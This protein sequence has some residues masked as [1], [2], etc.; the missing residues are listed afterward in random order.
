[1]NDTGE[2]KRILRLAALAQNDR[3]RVA[4][5]VGEVCDHYCKHPLAVTCLE[6]LDDICMGCPLVGLVELMCQAGLMK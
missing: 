5:L 2:E 6:E 4:E 1:M 3:D